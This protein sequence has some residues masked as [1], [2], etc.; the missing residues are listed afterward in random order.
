MADQKFTFAILEN[1]ATAVKNGL[2]LSETIINDDFIVNGPNPIAIKKA[3]YICDDGVWYPNQ[4]RRALSIGDQVCYLI[5]LKNYS[6]S[7]IKDF[8]II[9][10]MPV[11]FRVDD[12]KVLNVSIFVEEV[13]EVD[14]FDEVPEH[15]MEIIHEYTVTDEP[16]PVLSTVEDMN[17]LEKPLSIPIPQIKAAKTRPYSNH[18]SPT[19]CI[20][21]KILATFHPIAT[22]LLSE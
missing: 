11:G 18:T 14:F 21:V 6:P 20:A 19:E 15:F 5:F 1:K 22:T 8:Q 2:G 17:V 16:I 3:S 12:I 7:D 4:T 9:E 13:A 10:E